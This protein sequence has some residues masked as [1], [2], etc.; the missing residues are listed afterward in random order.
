MNQEKLWDHFQ[1]N[2]EGGDAFENAIPRYE[3]IAKSV[4][5]GMVVLNVGVGN[6]GIESILIGKRAIVHCLDPSED[7]IN[8]IRKNHK[9]GDQAK[10]GFSQDI[11][12][13]DNKFDVVIM[14]EVLEHLTEDVLMTTLL[15]VKR[16]LKSDGFFIGTVP[17]NEKLSDNQV[18]CPHCGV[19]SHRW[20]HVQS[21][22]IERLHEIFGIKKFRVERLEYRSFPSWRRRGIGNFIK[23]CVRYFLG[24]VGSPIA[25]PNIFFKVRS[26]GVK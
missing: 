4:D 2:F 14:T 13:K 15:E 24:R 8:R 16:V 26:S 22:S 5:S 10:V 17:A 6:G 23:S 9:L 11:P 19:V 21:F 3:F 25:S 18:F 1:N 20:G 12:F 7:A